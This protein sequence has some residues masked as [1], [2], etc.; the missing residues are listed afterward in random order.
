[1]IVVAPDLRMRSEVSTPTAPAADKNSC[2][3][4]EAVVT[5]ICI[6]SSRVNCFNFPDAAI[7][8]ANNEVWLI[9]AIEMKLTT[10]SH[11]W[12]ARH[13]IRNPPSV[14]N[15]LIITELFLYYS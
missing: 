14:K 13:S 12:N 1:M 5:S 8:W 2:G 10:V 15:D 4:L 11:I 7:C 6:N 9:H 3:F